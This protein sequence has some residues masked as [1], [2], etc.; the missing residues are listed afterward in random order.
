[1][2]RADIVSVGGIATD[3]ILWSEDLPRAGRCVVARAMHQGLGGKG[4]NQA[5]AAARLGGR[6]ALVGCVGGDAAGELA[7]RRLEGDGVRTDAVACIGGV[8]TGAVVLQRADGG[9]RQTAVFPGANAHL[10]PAAVMSAA[11]LIRAARVVLVQLEI[12]MDAV[13][14]VVEL[15]RASGTRLILDPSPV[16]PLPPDLLRAADVVKPNAFEATKLTGIEV[17]DRHSAREAARRLMEMGAGRVAVDAG[18]EGNLFVTP[19]EEVFLPLH[20]VNSADATGAG[21][22]LAAA[23]AVAMAEGQPWRAAA[24]FANAAAALATRAAGAQ[25]SMPTREEVEALRG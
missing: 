22:T 10:T 13:R 5:V 19:D 7:L 2:S 20:D 25:S 4:A 17:R 8:Q 23:L 3:L 24:T 18:G 1:M 9:A 14:C 16:R 21:D 11:P 6:V 15:V 12:P